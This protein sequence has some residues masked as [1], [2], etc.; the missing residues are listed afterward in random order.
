MYVMGK[1]DPGGEGRWERMDRIVPRI[2]YHILGKAR[3][4]SPQSSVENGVLSRTRCTPTIKVVIH[5]CP[6]EGGF[7]KVPHWSYSVLR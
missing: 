6:R 5:Q 7:Y 1:E 4:L 2:S 3:Y